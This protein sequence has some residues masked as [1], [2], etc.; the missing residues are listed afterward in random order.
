MN[1]SSSGW[2]KLMDS[3]NDF[4]LFSSQVLEGHLLTLSYY[5]SRVPKGQ[6]LG[7]DGLLYFECDS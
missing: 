1:H 2:P 7:R 6:T 5:R 3:D 4:C